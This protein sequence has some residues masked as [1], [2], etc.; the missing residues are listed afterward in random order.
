[1]DV[2]SPRC[3]TAT[4]PGQSSIP[5]PRSGA[6][7]GDARCASCRSCSANA[8]PTSSSSAPAIRACRR[9]IISAASG[10]EPDRARGQSAG[11]GRQRP[12]WRRH[13]SQVPSLIPGHRRKPWPRMA[14]RMYDIALEAVDMVVGA[15]GELWHRRRKSDALRPGQGRP[16]SRDTDLCRQGGRVGAQELGDTTMSVLDAEQVREETGSAALRRRRAAMR[17]RAAS[18][19]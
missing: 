14:K 18:I 16:Q 15:G 5:R 1:M 3:P 10:L 13:H 19:R 11:L 17:A 2:K 8:R 7:H 12:Q 4:N 9:R 6:R